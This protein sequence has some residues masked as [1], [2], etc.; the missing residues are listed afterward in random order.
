MGKCTD[1]PW[2]YSFTR[3]H[4]VVYHK[5]RNSRD[6]KISMLP[7]IN[8][9]LDSLFRKWSPQTTGKPKTARIQQWISLISPLGFPLFHLILDHILIYSPWPKNPPCSRPS[10]EQGRG[11]NQGT[12]L[13]HTAKLGPGFDYSIQKRNLCSLSI[14]T[15]TE[16]FSRIFSYQRKQC[17]NILSLLW[18]S[19]TRW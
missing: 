18:N 6:S 7:G 5:R 9:T 13:M 11:K 16:L 3:T 19:T 8:E 2:S 12:P 1:I 14:W 15:N 17:Q 10:P 4:R